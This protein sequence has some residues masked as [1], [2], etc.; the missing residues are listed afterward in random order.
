ML[1][2]DIADYA[3][4]ERSRSLPDD[5]LHYAKRAGDRLVRGDRTGQRNHA[6]RRSD[7]GLE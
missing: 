6:G 7:Q 3:I 4:L 2:F 5:V 1:I